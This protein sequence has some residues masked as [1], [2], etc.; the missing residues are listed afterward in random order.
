MK[1]LR[2]LELLSATL[3]LVFL[4]NLSSSNKVAAL[5]KEDTM[6]YVNDID[7]YN[8]SSAHVGGCGVTLDLDENSSGVTNSTT[9][10]LNNMNG[11]AHSRGKRFIAFPVGSSFSTAVCLT[12]GVV[13]NPDY[14]YLS[15]G[16]NWGI[17]YE[18][19]NTT[20]VLQHANGFGPKH[21]EK[22]ASPQIKRRHRRDLYGKLET[23]ING[24]CLIK[25]LMIILAV[26]VDD[27]KLKSEN[28]STFVTPH[29]VGD[30][31]VLAIN[32]FD[33]NFFSKNQ[34]IFD[35]L[36]RKMHTD[37]NDLLSQSLKNC[38]RRRTNN[39]VSKTCATN[40]TTSATENINSNIRT[41]TTTTQL[42][43]V[44]ATADMMTNTRTSSNMAKTVMSNVSYPSS[45]S[46]TS[47]TSSL[48]PI[49]LSSSST[50]PSLLLQKQQRLL[51]RPKRYLSFPE[52]S[53]FSVAVCFTVGIIGNP[54]YNYMSF[55]LNWGVAYDLPNTT[56]ILNHLHG[57][58]KR[59]IP[60]A[61]WHR[62]SKRSLYKEIENVVNN[63]GYNGR[64]CILR[65]LCESRQY[66]QKTKMGMIGE[67]LR[68]I[69]SLPKQR[70]FTRE[71][72]ENPDIGL[73]DGAYRKARSIS[74]CSEQYDCDFSLLE[75]AFGKYSTPPIGYY[76]KH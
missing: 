8:A 55:G 65:A 25:I 73:Y 31:D 51:S 24:F 33:G 41:Y 6:K 57:F 11:T 5:T 19:P 20:W 29:V 13:G 23:L 38:T 26:Y 44:M 43:T 68:V 66:F 9:R 28:C 39:C 15:M 18:L 74:D 47:A 27:V 58:A 45:L 32:N 36:Q 10:V 30:N 52:G 75:L 64:D 22:V 21:K 72:S 35:T 17:A 56:W 63:M 50:S 54:R 76:T 46:S 1:L 4:L 14:R 37:D 2:V 12:T 7:F 49:L 3:P 71:L 62:R 70:L 60:V 48:S 69:F 42:I 40:I 67:M 61:V 34:I 16:L 53:S 59:P